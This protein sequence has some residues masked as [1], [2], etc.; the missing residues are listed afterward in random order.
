MKNKVLIRR[1][2][3]EKAKKARASEEAAALQAL[4]EEAPKWSWPSRYTRMSTR[5]STREAI[6]TQ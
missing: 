1:E 3:A 4:G 2:I 6:I 5:R